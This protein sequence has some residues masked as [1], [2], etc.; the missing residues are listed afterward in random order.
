MKKHLLNLAM[1]GFF[2]LTGTLGFTAC[3]DDAVAGGDPS[4]EPSLSTKTKEVNVNF[5]M[6][7]DYG[8]PATTRQSAAT[9]QIPN[10]VS[11]T[12]R[13]IEQATLLP[14]IVPGTPKFL[15]SAAL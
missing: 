14:Y 13:G 7:V 10:T 2:A 4:V 15:N 8:Q 5:V 6:N 12:F 1:L 9:L 3:S 11:N